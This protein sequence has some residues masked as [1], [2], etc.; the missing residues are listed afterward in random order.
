M[1]I[2]QYPDDIPSPDLVTCVICREQKP[3]SSMSAGLVDAQEQQ[4]F[5]CESHYHEFR[6]LVIGWVDFA[7][8]QHQSQRR[9]DITALF[10]GGS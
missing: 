10:D 3:M 6:R 8:Q 2:I 7:I 4:A 5:A 9:G 1:A